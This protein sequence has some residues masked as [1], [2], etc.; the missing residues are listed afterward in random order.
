MTNKQHQTL[1]DLMFETQSGN[2][3]DAEKYGVAHATLRSL[4]QKRLATYVG[5]DLWRCTLAAIAYARTG[6]L[7]TPKPTRKGR[8]RPAVASQQVYDYIRNQGTAS[9]VELAE[10]FHVHR[11]SIRKAFRRLEKHELIEVH[12]KSFGPGQSRLVA[13]LK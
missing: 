10:V 5:D 2:L 12:R 9:T 6:I 13:T 1:Q 3:Y 8:G 7:P 4:E 11:S